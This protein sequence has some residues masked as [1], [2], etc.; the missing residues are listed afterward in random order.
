[1]ASV[2]FMTLRL[3]GKIALVTGGTR[4]IGLAIAENFAAEGAHVI[5]SGRDEERGRAIV[6]G[7]RAR[8]GGADFVATELDGSAERSE[9]LAVRSVELAG[10]R[11]DVLVNNAGIYPPHTTA[12]ADP[13]L[14]DLIFAVNLK[15]PFFLTRALIPQMVEVG[16]GVIINIG[17]WIARLA[18]PTSPIYSASKGAIETLTRSWSAEYG[19]RGIRVNAIS[20]G[21]IRDADAAAHAAERMMYGTPSGRSGRPDAIA[22]AA[23]YLASEESAFVHGV[24]LDVDGGRTTTAVI[25]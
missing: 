8:G 10:G 16:G 17:S 20:P 22:S 4:N 7:I 12:T 15:A 1:M 2:L 18:V 23:V 5:L 13:A 11:I 14:F 3:D 25:R 9:T 6:A 24:T 19:P 21:V